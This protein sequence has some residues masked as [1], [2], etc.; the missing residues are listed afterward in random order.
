VQRVTLPELERLGAE[1]LDELGPAPCAELL[2]ALLLPDFDRYPYAADDPTDLVDPLGL[3]ARQARWN[4]ICVGVSCGEIVSDMVLHF[5]SSWKAGSPYVCG[6]TLL[7]RA[8]AR[9]A[10][11]THSHS[12]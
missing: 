12:N 5:G 7:G 3:E 11:S 10:T 9:S 6:D 2:H 1:R 4:W 8:S